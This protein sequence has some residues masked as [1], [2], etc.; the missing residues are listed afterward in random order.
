MIYAY[1]DRNHVR[2]GLTLTWQQRN[3]EGDGHNV[4]FTI[5]RTFFQSGAELLLHLYV[6]SIEDHFASRT[7]PRARVSVPASAG[8]LRPRS[9][10]RGERLEVRLADVSPTGVAFI[11]NRTLPVRR[12]GRDLGRAAQRLVRLEARVVAQIPAVY[13]RNRVGCEITDILEAD[14]HWINAARAAS[15]SE[16]GSRGRPPDPRSPSALEARATRRRPGASRSAPPRRYPAPSPSLRADGRTDA[17]AAEVWVQRVDRDPHRGLA[18]AGAARRLDGEVVGLG[19]LARGSAASRRRTAPRPVRRGDR[20]RLAVHLVGVVAERDPVAAVA[21]Q[22][23]PLTRARAA[24]APPGRPAWPPFQIARE[25]QRAAAAS[26][27]PPGRSPSRRRHDSHGTQQTIAR[28]CR[29]PTGTGAAADYGCDPCPN[30]QREELLAL[31]LGR[32]SR[33]ARESSMCCRRT[34]AAYA[35]SRRPGGRAPARVLRRARRRVRDLHLLARVSTRRA[36][37]TRSSSRSTRPSSTPPPRR[38]CT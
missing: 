26:A 11:T 37:A 10:D 17:S 28:T 2:D 5:Q 34:V 30:A 22:R 25:H 1:G 13:G 15:P 23:H 16:Q 29:R 27:P 12:H 4:R 3:Q 20:R 7:A 36:A 32:A 35:L 19:Q 9:I 6:S 21:A 38:W 24:A 33:A 31:A 18:A 8:A 14:R